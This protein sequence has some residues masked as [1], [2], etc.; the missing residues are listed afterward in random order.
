M[1]VSGA[2]R[3]QQ[4]DVALAD[5]Q[6]HRLHALLLHGLAVLHRHPE[7]IGVEQ[8]GLLEVLHRHADVVDPPEHGPGG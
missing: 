1:A 2:E 6:Q 7:A 4:L 3:A 8:D 5:A